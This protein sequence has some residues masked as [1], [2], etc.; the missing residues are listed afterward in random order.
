MLIRAMMLMTVFCVMSRADDARTDEPLHNLVRIT[1]RVISGGG[2]EGDAAFAALRGMGIRTIISVDG[3][4]PDVE[5]ARRFGLR[6]VHLPIG[7]DEVADAEGKAIA[8]AVRTLPGPIFIH[9]HHGRH[10]GPAAAAVACTLTGE[11]TA[12]Q[13]VA[14][15]KQAGTGEHYRGL[16]SSAAEAKPLGVGVLDA[17]EVTFVEAAAVSDLAAA[18]VSIDETFE[19]L[20]AVRAAGWKPPADHPDIDPAHEAMLLWEHFRELA[21]LEITKPQT[22]GFRQS[23]VE[24]EAAAKA[25][26]TALRHL[27]RDDPAPARLEK[28]FRFV[29]QQC[30]ACHRQHRDQRPASEAR[31]QP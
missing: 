26:E 13:A 14:I 12:E 8:K 24:S 25:L 15:M 31:D 23:L 9:C 10:R 20:K 27:K 17:L 6:Y 29:Q 11:I 1:P 2:P 7:Y 21:R 30:T 22:A 18:M 5:R 16:W 28:S 19:H 4:K 3:A